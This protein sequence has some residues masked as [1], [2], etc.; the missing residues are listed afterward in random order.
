MLKHVCATPS[1]LCVHWPSSAG[2][3]LLSLPLRLGPPPV[4]MSAHYVAEYVAELVYV[5]RGLG[6][7]I[8]CLGE[9][10]A[11]IYGYLILLFGPWVLAQYRLC[12]YSPRFHAQYTLCI[13]TVCRLMRLFV[14][15]FR[16][17][18]IPFKEAIVVFSWTYCACTSEITWSYIL[19]HARFSL[20]YYIYCSDM[21][22]GW[23]G[24]R[25]SGQWVLPMYALPVDYRN[26]YTCTHLHAYDTNCI[27]LMI[28]APCTFI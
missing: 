27:H 21:R 1:I 6:I 16:R 14:P 5:F 17:T 25:G 22:S 28:M 15:V 12:S 20:F 9:T 3:D 19:A 24:T 26:M 23:T 4:W 18:G 10:A 11:V 7:S 2:L 13:N 8:H